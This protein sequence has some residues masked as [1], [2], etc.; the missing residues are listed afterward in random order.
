MKAVLNAF[1]EQINLNV[2]AL[3][4]ESAALEEINYFKANCWL[5]GGI[6]VEESNRFTFPKTQPEFYSQKAQPLYEKWL[7]EE[8][9]ICYRGTIIPDPGKM[10]LNQYLEFLFLELL[11]GMEQRA[12]CNDHYVV[13]LAISEMISPSKCRAL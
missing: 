9:D 2:L 3:Q 11:Q 12:V 10:L 1:R 4:S 5:A 13:L 8:K 6:S 7:L